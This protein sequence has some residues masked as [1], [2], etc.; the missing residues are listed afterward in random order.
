MSGEH[1]ISVALAAYRGER[2]IVAQLESLLGQTRTPD[3]IVICDDSPDERTYQA[4]RP[5]CE[6]F[7]LIRYFRNEPR[8]DVCRNFEKAISLCT[9][10][11]I[12]LA[13]Q[14]DIWDPDKIA[15]LSGMLID[16]AGCELVFC[17]SRVVDQS[18]NDL[19][20]TTLDIQG[21]DR[22]QLT[23]GLECQIRKPAA[24]AHNIAFKRI[25]L[26]YAL[27]FPGIGA[28]HD[29]WLSMIAAARNTLQI[30]PGELTSYRFHSDNYTILRKQNFRERFRQ[31]RE[32]GKL[33]LER[34]DRLYTAL[35]ERLAGVE[36]TPENRQLLDA[37]AGY[38]QLR[39]CG[40]WWK[41]PMK[42][43][44]RFGSGWK[45]LLRD[46]L[47]RGSTK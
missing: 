46:I 18:L 6:R 40:R 29:F 26:D 13:D 7:P 24:Y 33:E 23:P 28:G 36:L 47:L 31:L 44:V 25:L 10:D 35:R 8:L 22:R 45:S 17:H 38:Y 9:G 21:I 16:S 42:D 2:W 39:N 3:E 19:H 11:I 41:I 12:F 43:Y 1:T 27:P 15:K 30:F 5:L 32:K 20:Y 37:A 4:I 14:D 34:T